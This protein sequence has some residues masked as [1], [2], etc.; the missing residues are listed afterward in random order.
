MLHNTYRLVRVNTH[1]GVLCTHV[2]VPHTRPRSIPNER[3]PTLHR[4]PLLVARAHAHEPQAAFKRRHSQHVWHCGS[5]R[6]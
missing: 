5:I 1:A 2:I 6:E 3:T 4:K